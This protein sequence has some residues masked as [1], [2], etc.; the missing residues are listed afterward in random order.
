MT[1]DNGNSLAAN[2]FQEVLSELSRLDPHEALQKIADELRQ[3]L[4]CETVCILLWNEEKQKLIT[5]YRSGLPKDLTAP[6]QYG[7]DEGITGKYIFSQ[8]RLVNG[9][10]DVERK[11]FVDHEAGSPIADDS[12][13]WVNIQAFK[14][15][16]EFTEFKSLLGAPCFNQNQKPGVVKLINKKDRATGGLAEE[17]FD[18]E[19]VQKLQLFLKMIEFILQ[20]KW[21]EKRIESLFTLVE[22]GTVS[23]GDYDQALEEM[24]SNCAKLL[25]YRACVVRLFENGR[26]STRA[27][28][29]QPIVSSDY[30]PETDPSLFAFRRKSAL[31]WKGHPDGELSPMVFTGLDGERHSFQDP[32]RRITNLVRRYRLKSALITPIVVSGG[33]VVGTFECYTSVPHEF[34]HQ[35]LD[36]IS[37]YANSLINHLRQYRKSEISALKVDRDSERLSQMEGLTQIIN[38]VLNKETLTDLYELIL[39]KTIDYFKFDYGAIS[40]VDYGAGRVKTERGKSAKPHLINPDDWLTESDYNLDE[41]D[42]EVVPDILVDVIRKKKS[43]LISGPAAE[44]KWDPRLNRKIYEENSHKDLIRIYVPFTLRK[45]GAPDPDDDGGQRSIEE[46]V[47][48]IIE[49]G[50]HV[51]TQ[52]YIAESRRALFELFIN[53]CAGAFERLVSDE[54]DRILE[55]LNTQES[56]LSSAEQIY[57][58]LREVVEEYLKAD[59]VSVW[60]KS[61]TSEP[62]K[63]RLITASGAL[64]G[65]YQKANIQEL[66]HDSYTVEAIRKG[67]VG[68][69]VEVALDDFTIRKF[70]YPQIARDNDLETIVIIPISIGQ[71]TYAVVDVF[72]R[73][74]RRLRGEEREFLER[75]A[76]RAAVAMIAVQNAKLVN[77]FSEISEALLDENIETILKSITENALEVLHANPVLLFRYDSDEQKFL[78]DVISAG[79]FHYPAVR[80]IPEEVKENDWPN[81]ILNLNEV[82]KYL[83][84]EEEYLEFQLQT[85]RVWE[86]DRFPDD[87][88]HREEIKS[89]AAL[90]LEHKNEPLGVMFVNYRTPQKFNES[91]RKLVEAF[92]AQAAAAIAH[93]KISEHHRQFYEAQRRNSLAMS[94]SEIVA[95]LAHNSGN[96]LDI[97]RLRY[98]SFDNF[99]KKADGRVEKEKVQGFME[100]LR[101]PLTELIADFEGLEEYRKFSES[102]LE[103]DPCLVED[104][105]DGSLFMLRNRLEWNK[106]TVKKSYAHPP[107]VLCDKHQIQHVLLNLLINAL[108]AMGRRG[109]LSVGT[110]VAGEYVRIRITDSG[111]GITPENYAR[112]FKP[113]FTTKKQGTG[114]GLPISRYIA[115]R[116]GGRIDFASKPGKEST[117]VI[118]LPIEG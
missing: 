112:I 105:I 102:E 58:T 26:L 6:E 54:A 74:G 50:Y 52:T 81:I 62:F 46:K 18:S 10:V 55:K 19:D 93:A 90:R 63:L 97:I 60:E 35:E 67:R 42:G 117:F 29:V 44:K 95:S 8:G 59:M 11:T 94:V 9:R 66:P 98:A 78:P 14:E 56:L 80:D 86:G 45:T 106:I 34:S 2:K 32:P 33:E 96:L 71:E 84:T 36:V 77:S 69:V 53:Y 89:S 1:E 111:V 15:R 103:K 107:Q 76:G 4:N 20:S 110:D 30:D 51:S 73:R 68:E 99:L 101:E 79:H 57:V 27:Y 24:V 25:N 113:F 7:P 16:S 43:E 13:K 115:Q 72:L 37:K 39:D 22:Q 91:T 92:A 17:G 100:Q 28:N 23:T 47:V 75:F 83:E 88:W 38:D 70:A 31:R 48:G 65:Q 21:N 109:T 85:N 108:D 12:I 40:R 118:Y 5:E 116:H 87:F 64:K 82:P 104:L 3:V 61:T 49:A 41:T 114:L